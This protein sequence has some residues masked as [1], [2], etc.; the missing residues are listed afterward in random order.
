[1]SPK[2]KHDALCRYA[3]GQLNDPANTLN[4]DQWV[5]ILNSY[6][7]KESAEACAVRTGLDPIQVNIR[8]CDLSIELL[9]NA[10]NRLNGNP[11]AMV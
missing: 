6:A 10:V 8:F 4:A 5:S 2:E 11:A 7:R 3:A 9:R 1:M